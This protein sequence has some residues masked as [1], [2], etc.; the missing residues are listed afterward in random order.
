MHVCIHNMC[1]LTEWKTDYPSGAKKSV[2]FYFQIIYSMSLD[3]K[4]NSLNNECV[5][6]KGGPLLLFILLGIL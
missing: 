3:Y 4:R 2:I 6:G 5:A 1:T